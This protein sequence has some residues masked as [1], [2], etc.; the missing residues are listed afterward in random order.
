MTFTD[1]HEN[2][3]KDLCARGCHRKGFRKVL[4]FFVGA[5]LHQPEE[6]L[7]VSKL[8]SRKMYNAAIALDSHRRKL[9]KKIDSISEADLSDRDL[10]ALE[11]DDA[12]SSLNRLR[13]IP[14][15][16]EI[17]L[18]RRTVIVHEVVVKKDICP[19]AFGEL[20]FLIDCFSWFT[21]L[22]VYH[23]FYGVIS[24]D[25]DDLAKLFEDWCGHPNYGEKKEIRV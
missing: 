18:Q 22:R 11:M 23:D 25:D 7:R 17:D 10:A 12:W 5:A 14:D 24:K 6:A 16:F 20:W 2:A 9:L 1:R 4:A 3:V 13:L 21:E 19:V 8:P 15:A